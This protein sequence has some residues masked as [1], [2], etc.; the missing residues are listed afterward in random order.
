MDIDL[1]PEMQRFVEEKM[2]AGRYASASDLVNDAPAALRSEEEL[3]AQDILV[4]RREVMIGVE[5]H[6]RGEST[7]LDMKSIRA[8][9]FLA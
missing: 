3:S 7:P 6:R 2:R 9:V 1:N 5:Q 8:Q 4:L